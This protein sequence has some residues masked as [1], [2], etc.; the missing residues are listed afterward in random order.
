M[1]RFY[2]EKYKVKYNEDVND[3]LGLY[4]SEDEVNTILQNL[5]YGSKI[6]IYS[7]SQ[8]EEIEILTNKINNKIVESIKAK[9]E[10]RFHILS[11][12]FQLDPF[13]IDILLI[14]L[15]PELDL[16]YEKLYA[17]L[18]DDVTKKRPGV[19]LVLT[20]LCP[21]IEERFSAREKFSYTGTL[22]N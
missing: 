21:S 10:L 15:A 18:Q 3:L 19:D 1:I 6:N 14:C 11:E 7:D 9:K 2:L 13:E 16:R 22:I 12:L 5:P 17:Y 20:L 4:I 8:F